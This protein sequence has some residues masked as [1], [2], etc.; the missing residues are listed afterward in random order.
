MRN[1]TQG[2][3]PNKPFIRAI[4]FAM[5]CPLVVVDVSEHVEEQVAGAP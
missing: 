2:T 3:Q 1:Y 4:A 5:P